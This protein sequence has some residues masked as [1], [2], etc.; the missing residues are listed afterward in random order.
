MEYYSTNQRDTYKIVEKLTTGRFKNENELL[1]SLVRE[2]VDFRQFEIIGGRV[3]ELQVEENCYMLR[4]Q[5]GSLEKIPDEY[6]FSI[7]DNPDIFFKL[8]RERTSL[9]YETDELLKQKGIN[10]YSVSG[11]GEIVRTKNGRFYKYLLSFNAPEIL[12]SF[13]ETLSVISSV[14]TIALRNLSSQA[15]QEKM[16]QDITSASEIQRNLLPEHKLKFHDYD[17]FGVCI[18][19]EAVG[20]DY[21]DYFKQSDVEDEHLGIVISDAASKGLPAAIQALFVS[22]AIRMAKRFSPKISHLMNGLNKLIYDTFPFERFVTLFYCE[23]TMSSNRLVLYANAGHCPPVHYRAATDEIRLLGSTG[24]LLGLMENQKFKVE[25]IRMLPG[26]VLVL[27]TD[28]ITEG[29]DNSGQLFGD[30]RLND[31][32]K[33]YHNETPK[34]IA[35][36]ILEEVQKFTAGSNFTDDRT[37][38]I[39]KR[40]KE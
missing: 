10:I 31:L 24:G 27:Y 17:I 39:I 1:K 3:W 21:F 2:I 4:Y 19:D 34:D 7:A 38:V 13:F 12:Q 36:L 18:P 22:G 30:E 5:Y 35:M 33:K 29:R 16:T 25:N 8:I 6:R 26:D 28:G 32:V 37:L 14:A 23:L 20:G 15:E 40:D 11:V 9:N